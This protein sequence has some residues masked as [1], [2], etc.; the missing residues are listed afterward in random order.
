MRR[1]TKLLLVAFLLLT[2]VEGVAAHPP[3]EPGH[4]LNQSEWVKLWSGDQGTALDPNDSVSNFVSHTS[5]YSFLNP[6]KTTN[7]WNHGEFG[8]LTSIDMHD[9]NTSV[10][11]EGVTTTESVN[12]TI[13]DA[14]VDVFVVEPSTIAH[15]SRTSTTRYIG[16]EGVVAAVVDYRVD[17]QKNQELVSHRIT[18]TSLQTGGGTNWLFLENDTS[19]SH[20]PELNYD[21]RRIPLARGLNFRLVSRI[22]VRV[23]EPDPG[24]PGKTVVTRNLTVSETIDARVNP[25]RLVAFRSKYPNGDYGVVVA[26]VGSLIRSIDVPGGSIR[27]QWR[28]Y[29][30]RDESWDIL[31]VDNSSGITNSHSPAHPVEIHTYPSSNGVRAL[32][33]TQSSLPKVVR[34]DGIRYPAPVLSSDISVDVV[35]DSY[36]TV[37]GMEARYDP[38][39][40]DGGLG[41][42]GIVRGEGGEVEIIGSREMQETEVLL[43]VIDS[44]ETHVKLNVSLQ[45]SGSGEP[46]RLRGREGYIRVMANESVNTSENGSAE[47]WIKKP[48]DYVRAEYIP[49]AWWRQS[50]A[51]LPDETTLAVGTEF[52]GPLGILTAAVRLLGLILPALLLVFFADRVLGLNVWPPWKKV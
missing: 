41:Y 21:I 16:S 18:R 31:S 28:Y 2:L 15:T 40:G 50:G 7:W 24:S 38:S 36:Q 12:G 33:T 22:E 11:P 47:L 32:S 1:T 39:E 48:S 29:T 6:P 27:T 44:N 52:R 20:T 19:G 49:G 42:K 26:N 35:E 45:V 3:S 51:Y 4:G 46:I 25:S 30:A 5:D 10:R 14:Y 17:L 8:D 9:P 37:R 43:S 23:R 13:K 34:T